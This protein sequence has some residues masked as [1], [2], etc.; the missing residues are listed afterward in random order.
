LLDR[1]SF[2]MFVLKPF[3]VFAHLVIINKPLA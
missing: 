3:I 2:S 1:V